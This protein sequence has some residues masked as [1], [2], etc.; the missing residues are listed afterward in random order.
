MEILYWK[1]N[2]VYDHKHISSL[3]KL[4]KHKF[5]LM[6]CLTDVEGKIIHEISDQNDI[7]YDLGKVIY[8]SIRTQRE[9]ILSHYVNKNDFT[10]IMETYTG[11]ILS[12]ITKNKIPISMFIKYLTKPDIYDRLND[13]D[14]K[15][16]KKLQVCLET[17]NRNIQQNAVEFENDL[18][19][20]LKTVVET[21]FKTEADIKKQGNYVATPDILF[22]DPIL[23]DVN[24]IKT[25]IKWIDAK[26][27]LLC[28]IP[29][30]MK[31][32][33]KQANKYYEIYGMGAFVFHYGID[34]SISIP[35]AIV[36]DGSWIV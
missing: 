33:R 11:N 27:Y 32:L 24:G 16:I 10:N 13:N 5:P 17:N 35:G 34:E 1:N 36:L 7:S 29:F 3:I 21:P 19:R 9:I 25:Q 26:N 14:Q 6:L 28:D 2:L 23:L 31:S 18:A 8:N 4:F 12:I 30:I 15:Y 22:D 20:Y